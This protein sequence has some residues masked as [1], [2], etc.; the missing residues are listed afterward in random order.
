MHWVNRIAAV[1]VGAARLG[2]LMAL[3][4]GFVGCASVGPAQQTS[5]RNVL[6]TEKFIQAREAQRLSLKQPVSR[7]NPD[8]LSARVDQTLVCQSAY[9]DRVATRTVTTRPIKNAAAETVLA[10]SAAAGGGIALAVSPGLSD[11]KPGPSDSS[12]Q[13][14]ARLWGAVGLGT[15]AVLLGHVIWVAAKSSDEES[16]PVIT[17][18]VRTAGS[19]PQD[20]GTEAAGP[21]V[22]RARVDERVIELGQ[23]SSGVVELNLRS[24]PDSLCGDPNA[25]DRAAALEF[26]LS[27][28]AGVTISLG[29]Y[30]LKHCVA[31]TAARRKLRLAETQLAGGVDGKRV[32][33]G[34]KLVNDA[35]ALLETLPSSDPDAGELHVEAVRLRKL[36]EAKAAA[37]SHSL[38][39]DA[40]TK[41]DAKADDAVVS[42]L[43][44][45]EVS[46]L[47]NTQDEARGAIYAA[48]GRQR[49][50]RAYS[51][52]TLLMDGDQIA[53][54]CLESSS[55]CPAGLA[56]DQWLMLLQPLTQSVAEM[57]AKQAASLEAATTG[58]SKSLNPKTLAAFDTAV[59]QAKA[60]AP[61]C[62]RSIE[63][64]QGACGRL[65][66][67]D[68]DASAFGEANDARLRKLRQEVAAK[69]RADDLRKTTLRW[70]RHFAECSHLQQGVRALESISYCDGA[71]QAVVSRMRAQNE[72]LRA[73]EYSEIVDEPQALQKLV[74][75]CNAAGCAACP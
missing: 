4:P 41:V 46:A 70:R 44:A 16:E 48:L 2:F 28:G 73:F 66:D 25:G 6:H 17:E 35:G 40:V 37:V 69:Q 12:P 32:A 5:V 1:A 47:S 51:Q 63:A 45:I 57:V 23:F 27:A 19:R 30:K 38:V 11:V 75:E 59:A 39:Q 36:A 13:E 31:A 74:D 22:V 72:R 54:G 71:C 20:C 15:G 10:L 42:S 58:I 9:R 61:A 53:R 67:V 21:G 18:E 56:R 26:V 8:W 64:L 52:L 14:T 3:F 60:S 7:P 65:V 50:V 34:V 43:E 68:A 49:G 55:R 33:Q 29:E 62:Q 24:R